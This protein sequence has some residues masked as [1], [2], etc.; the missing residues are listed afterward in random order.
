[1]TAP[2]FDHLNIV[3]SDLAASVAFYRGLFGMGVAL[4]CRL[5]GPWFEAVTGLPGAE[6]DCVILCGSD[7]GLRIELLRYL[8]PPGESW[9]AASRLTTRGLRHVAIRVDDLD[10]ALARARS[11]GYAIGVEPVAVPLTILAAGK[12]MAYFQDPDGV[13]LELADYGRH[14]QA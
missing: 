13:V 11:L 6:A 10:A 8:N 2:R 3:V 14:P 1:M 9:P 5:S 4:D 7:P 12:R